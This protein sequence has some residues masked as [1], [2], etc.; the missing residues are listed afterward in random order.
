MTSFCRYRN[1]G[2]KADKLGVFVRPLKKMGAVWPQGA[3]WVPSTTTNPFAIA[4]D[5]TTTTTTTEGSDDSAVVLGG[6]TCKDQGHCVIDNIDVCEQEAVK[7][8]FSDTKADSINRPALAPG[9]VQ[10]ATGVLQF[11][12]AITGNKVTRAR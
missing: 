6:G 1:I 7:W 2:R 4:T 8:G 10:S 12:T 9:C 3:D 5:T 11:N